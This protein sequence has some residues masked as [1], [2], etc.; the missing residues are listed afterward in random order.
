MQVST[1]RLAAEIVGAVPSQVTDPATVIEAPIAV[2]A[3]AAFALV[4]LG[5]AVLLQ[6]RG[7]FVY[8]AIDAALDHPVWSVGYGV[9]SHAVIGFAAAYLGSQLALVDVAGVN[10]GAVGLLVAAILVGL[11]GSLGFTVV[12]VAVADVWGTAS[13]WPGVAL[14]ALLAGGV[15]SLEPMVAGVAW[16][17]VVSFGIGGAVREWLQA[18]AR[19]DV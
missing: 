16:V 19:T 6:R 11:S 1:A 9:A 2:R 5:G 7:R 18:S 14:G 8:E 10:F 17:A 4:L 12:G 3:A 15:A 13:A